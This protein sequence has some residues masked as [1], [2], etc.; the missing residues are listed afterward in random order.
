[1]HFKQYTAEEADWYGYNVLDATTRI[2]E[3]NE[4]AQ[5]ASIVA[6]KHELRQRLIEDLKSVGLQNVERV[7]RT[8]AG[9]VVDF[10][11]E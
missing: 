1:M 7:V 11:G 2:K 6:L 9:K 3:L 8:E 4:A 5:E 10:S